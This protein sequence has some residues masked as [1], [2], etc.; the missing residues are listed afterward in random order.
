MQLQ[1]KPAKTIHTF[2]GIPVNELTTEP[3]AII[4]DAVRQNN[5]TT[6][7]TAV[8]V[9][10]VLPNLRFTTSGMVTA[11]VLR[12]FGAKYASGII[13]TAAANTYHAALNPQPEKALAA[14]PVVLPPPIL[15]AERED[16][17]INSPI[18]RPASM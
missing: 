4:C 15:L 17:T 7:S 18:L 11:I 10:A 9:P 12:I 16:A 13:A 1:Q 3:E 14:T 2:R 8:N 6:L 5:D